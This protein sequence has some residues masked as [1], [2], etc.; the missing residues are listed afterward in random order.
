[1]FC[2]GLDMCEN[3]DADRKRIHKEGFVAGS[4][5]SMR[6]QRT[7]IPARWRNGAHSLWDPE[8]PEGPR[9][10]FLPPEDWP[11]ISPDLNPLDYCIWGALEQEVYRVPPTNL[12]QLNRRIRGALKKFSLP[13]LNSS[14]DRF[15]TRLRKCEEA[16]GGYFE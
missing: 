1:M 11:P 3:R 10:Q 5:S 7:E 6:E 2:Y 15:P 13:S 9:L 4:Y 12:E 14:I 16:D 8:F